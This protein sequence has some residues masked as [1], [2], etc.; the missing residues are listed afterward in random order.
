MTSYYYERINKL[1]L[2]LERQP[3]GT[4]VHSDRYDVIRKIS[5]H[6]WNTVNSTDPDDT[7]SDEDI[8]H[9]I[10]TMS[11]RNNPWSFG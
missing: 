7:L 8:A 9:H 6:V 10:F 11:E 4:F 2:E 1:V 3:V 5:D